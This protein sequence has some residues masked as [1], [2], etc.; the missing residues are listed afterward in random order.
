MCGMGLPVLAM[1]AVALSMD[2]FV[3]S[4]VRGMT[5]KTPGGADALATAAFFG[6]AQAL[7]PA[8]G[9]FFGMGFSDG[10][11]RAGGR[12]ISA[13]I[14][15]LLGLRMLASARE[16]GTGMALRSGKGYLKV[17]AAQAVATSLDALAA[18]VGLRAI[19]GSIVLP[20]AVIGAAAFVLSLAGYLL[21]AVFYPG[22]ACLRAQALGGVL[23]LALAVRTLFF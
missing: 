7:M 13:G 22:Q 18:G 5:Q 2:A 10:V 8:L 4:V 12:F 3:M 16:G 17:L 20:A 14:F 19:C 21:G 1:M 11:L 15:A 23:L 9:F 6:A